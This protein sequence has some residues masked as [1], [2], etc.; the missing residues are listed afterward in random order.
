VSSRPA[1]L[2]Q[3]QKTNKQTNKQIPFTGARRMTNGL[4]VDAAKQLYKFVLARVSIP[5]QTS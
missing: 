2:R 4:R 3:A 1:W 5:P